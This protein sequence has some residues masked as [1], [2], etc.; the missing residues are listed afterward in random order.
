MQQAMLAFRQRE[1]KHK[2]E[3]L[4]DVYSDRYVP[5]KYAKNSMEYGRPPPGSLTEMRAKKAGE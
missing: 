2:L 5:R 1:E 3:S 4:S